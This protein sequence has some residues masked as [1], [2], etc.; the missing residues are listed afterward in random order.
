LSSIGIYLEN[1]GLKEPE[2]S[3]SIEHAISD[4]VAQAD[5]LEQEIDNLRHE[6]ANFGSISDGGFGESADSFGPSLSVLCYIAPVVLIPCLIVLGALA[7]TT[8]WPSTFT[9]KLNKSLGSWLVWALIIFVWILFP[10]VGRSK[11]GSSKISRQPARD[12]TRATRAEMKQRIERATA[13]HAALIA[14]KIL[15]RLIMPSYELFLQGEAAPLGEVW[16]PRY[17]TE[18]KPRKELERQLSLMSGG[19]I[20]F[21]G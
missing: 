12:E 2:L 15:E 7:G 11:A 13:E 21:P 16:D 10:L 8:G 19:S 9:E 3:E 1:V 20:G 17:E 5:R 14:R 4:P 18:T 6:I